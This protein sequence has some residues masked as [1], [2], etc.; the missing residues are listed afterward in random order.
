MNEE[1]KSRFR[2]LNS[3]SGS[4]AALGL[5]LRPKGTVVD[6]LKDPVTYVGRLAEGTSQSLQAQID[7]LE[8]E[9][10]A[11]MVLLRLDPT[12][13][14]HTEFANRNPIG[15]TDEDPSFKRFKE[16]IKAHGQD[17]PVRVRPATPG[18]DKR[19][20]IVEGHRRHAAILQLHRETPGDFRFSRG[21]MQARP[22]P[23]I[24]P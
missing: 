14:G 12:T 1:R 2:A 13:I 20:E 11:G 19:F 22:M 3:V 15:L 24:S 7:A 16:G 8:A 6:P 9:R 5:G 18:S 21:S 17:T 23:V 4:A 10:S